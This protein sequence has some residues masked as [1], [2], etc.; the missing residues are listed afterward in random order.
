M[1]VKPHPDQILPPPGVRRGWEKRYAHS[2]LLAYAE[3]E[4]ECSIWLPGVRRSKTYGTRSCLRLLAYAEAECE[5]TV[6]RLYFHLLAYAEVEGTTATCTSAP[7]RTPGLDVR[8]ETAC[9]GILNRCN[10]TAVRA[11]PCP[12]QMRL[13]PGPLIKS[14]VCV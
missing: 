11:F 13:K 3:V 8:R 7:W 14:C 12:H 6:E 2:H 10:V 1:G 4:S 5:A 9:I